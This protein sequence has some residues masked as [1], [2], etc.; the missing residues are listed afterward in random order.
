MKTAGRPSAYG[1]IST[2]SFLRHAPPSL[3][4]S[5]SFQPGFLALM[6]SMGLSCQSGREFSTDLKSGCGFR[7][8][9]FSLSI[10]AC[11]PSEG[12]KWT[13][14]SAIFAALSWGRRI[15]FFSLTLSL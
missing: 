5:P 9:C 8:T 11:A 12:P 6:Y 13:L 14:P 15:F 2:C 3:D 4:P 7:W 10:M 1:S